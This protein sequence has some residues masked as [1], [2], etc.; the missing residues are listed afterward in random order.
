MNSLE[1]A[2]RISAELGASASTSEALTLAGTIMKKELHAG[3]AVDMLGLVRLQLTPAAIAGN[4]RGKGAISVFPL[5]GIFPK[6]APERKGPSVI[7]IALETVDLF[8]KIIQKNLVAGG[9]EVI[10]VEGV[11]E[12]MK[13]VKERTVDAIALDANMEMSDDVRHWLKSDPKRSLISL[14]SLYSSQEE[15][16]KLNS[17]K[18]SED[19]SLIEPYEAEDLGVII[20]SEVRRIEAEKKHFSHVFGFQ[21]PAEV[22]YQQQAADLI[23]AS[24]RKSGLSEEGRM[25]LIV[26]FR[27]AIDN[28]IRH[29]SK[30]KSNAIVTV[31]YVL[32]HEK[33]TITIEDEGPGFDSSI[34]IDNRVS[35][36]AV[37]AARKRHREG[38]RGGLG[39]M[40]ML[41]SVDKLEYNREGNTVKI[42]KLLKAK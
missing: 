37:A 24:S 13:I 33:M 31:A 8:A 23:E 4:I 40:L 35:S 42:T 28:A 39:I 26:A 32:D 17:L 12:L 14:I 20:D 9:R 3:N 27:E 25:G 5:P 30:E 1:L 6:V 7:I 15:A 10:L 22:A 2:K 16:D 38:G 19:G 29:G 41:K 11:Q 21:C 36:D 34:Y 18:V